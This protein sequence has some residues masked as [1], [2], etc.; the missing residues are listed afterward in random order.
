[1]LKVLFILPYLKKLQNLQNSASCVVIL[2][3]LHRE[4]PGCSS[5]VVYLAENHI[6]FLGFPGRRKWLSSAQGFRQWI[7]P[8]YATVWATGVQECFFKLH[9]NKKWS[10][11]LWYIKDKDCR[12]VLTFAFFPSFFFQRSWNLASSLSE[13]MGQELQ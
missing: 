11:L 9:S 7:I 3:L 6:V 8:S 13:S 12:K 10:L 1:M 5:V 4:M 2:I